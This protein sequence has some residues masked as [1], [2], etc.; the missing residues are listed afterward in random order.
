MNPKPNQKI[1][2]LSAIVA[3]QIINGTVTFSPAP[4]PGI[5]T[6]LAEFEAKRILNSILLEEIEA[7]RL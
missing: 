4:Q 5:F 7:G 2:R 1:F 3:G 6:A